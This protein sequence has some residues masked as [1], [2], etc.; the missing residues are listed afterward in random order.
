MKQTAVE[1]LVK[2]LSDILGSIDIQPMQ[3][4]LMTDAIKKAKEMEK[5]NMINFLKSVFQQ[6]GFDYGKAF[7]Q[8]KKK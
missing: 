5:E 6:D 2:E 1:Y 7:E 8:F 4:L 3:N